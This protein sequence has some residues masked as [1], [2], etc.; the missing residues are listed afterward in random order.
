MGKD[1]CQRLP[2]LGWHFPAQEG[3]KLEHYNSGVEMKKLL[4]I[5][6]KTGSS[7]TTVDLVKPQISTSFSARL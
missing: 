4:S 5:K 3:K 1:E 7:V 2:E 6:G